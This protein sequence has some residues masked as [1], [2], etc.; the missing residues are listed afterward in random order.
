M[1]PFR[2]TLFV[3][4]NEVM[5]TCP[6]CHWQNRLIVDDNLRKGEEIECSHC[7]E[8][9]GYWHTDRQEV[10]IGVMAAIAADA[11]PTNETE[12]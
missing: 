8:Y 7:R 5:I 10:Y 2:R 12:V 11:R 3:G 9:L 1:M 4:G 6:S